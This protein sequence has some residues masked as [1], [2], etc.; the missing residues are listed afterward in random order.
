MDT[1]IKIVEACARSDAKVR[2]IEREL[3]TGQIQVEEAIDRI[4][5]ETERVRKE[6]KDLKNEP[7]RENMYQAVDYS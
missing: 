6:I 1:L 5:G 4:S 2:Q 3:Y 7:E